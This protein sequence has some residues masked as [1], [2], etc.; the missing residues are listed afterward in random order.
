MG[1]IQ[2]RQCCVLSS[3]QLFETPWA[4]A[5]E[6]PLL[7]WVAISSL[8]GSSVPRGWT[9]IS[10][11]S[12]ITGGFFTSQPSGKSKGDSTCKI[13]KVKRQP[14]EREKNNSKCSNWQTT[15][16][17]NIQATL[18]VQ[19]QKNKWSNQKMGQRTKSLDKQRRH[20]DG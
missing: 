13:S 14:S 7:E 2:R 6:A 1:R 16:L 9:C 18:A 20:T 19:F 5:C 10:L 8:R 4:I 12:S 15:N 11:V 17:K 3:V